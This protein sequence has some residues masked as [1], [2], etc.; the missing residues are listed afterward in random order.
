MLSTINSIKTKDSF[1]SPS[2]WSWSRSRSSMMMMMM[3]SSFFTVILSSWMTM[4]WVSW[5]WWWRW[6]WRC[7]CSRRWGWRSR[8]R[9]RFRSTC[10]TDFVFYWWTST[11]SMI[12]WWTWSSFIVTI[13]FRWMTSFRT[14]HLS[15]KYM[16]IYVYMY[17]FFRIIIFN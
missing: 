16:Y 4:T 6:W 12:D 11:S 3:S 13:T 17:R 9:S 1:Y 15:K 5:S 2:S 10:S 8:W 7:W 14:S